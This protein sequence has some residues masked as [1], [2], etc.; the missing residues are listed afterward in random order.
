MRA[1]APASSANLGPGFDALAVALDCYV[2]VEVEPAPA[3]R[4]H[5]EGEGAGLADDA[6]H[7]AV[8]VA[9][10]ILGHDRIAVTVR[11][12]IP[13]SRGLGSS[14]AL[15][16]A[17][18]A[19]AGS[20]EPFSVAAAWDGH[21]E[22]AAASVFGGLVAATDVEGKPS[23]AQLPLSAELA[24]VVI[25]PDRPLVTAEAR[26]VLPDTLSRD[27]ALFNLGRMGLLLA[28]MADPTLLTPA[29][30][31]DRLHQD[32][33]AALFPEAQALLEALVASG[34]L[35]S[36]WSGAGPSL[37]AIIDE[38]AT[39]KVRAGALSALDDSGLSGRVLL[40]RSDRRGLVHGEA[41]EMPSPP[42]WVLGERRRLVR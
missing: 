36:C 16:A 20:D 13:V 18:A 39:D 12:Q 23:A 11:S 38:S 17:A 10:S 5:S 37:L 27:D 40:L 25:V 33:R 2:Q 15:A 30:T 7:L 34:A 6:S 4:V 29:A 35:A 19:A 3:L 22:N 24:F 9:R 8:R 21:P 28:G 26:A 31:A 41:A 32:A 42:S 1:R 14:A